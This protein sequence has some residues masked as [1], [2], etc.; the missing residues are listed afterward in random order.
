MTFEEDSL[1]NLLRR[2]EGIILVIDKISHFLPAFPVS[3]LH[4]PM[5]SPGGILQYQL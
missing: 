4:V 2:W 3:W 1:F 5:E